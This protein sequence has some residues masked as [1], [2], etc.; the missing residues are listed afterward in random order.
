MKVVRRMGSILLWVLAVIGALSGAVFVAHA[1]G[2]VQPLVVVSGSMEPEIRRGDLIITI[3]VA[4]SDVEIGEVTTL[5][6]DASGRLVTHRVIAV[7][8][9]GEDYVIKMQGDAN[10]VP[11]P[12]PYRVAAT[13][14]VLQPVV[15]IPAAGDIVLALAR[16]TVAIPLAVAVLALIAFSLVPSR[17]P[18]RHLATGEESA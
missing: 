2:W 18:A 1:L 11:D 4:A 16:P 7:N 3:P 15:T 10:G 8:R 17:T 5:R 9:S 12:V 13:D 14:S 6:S